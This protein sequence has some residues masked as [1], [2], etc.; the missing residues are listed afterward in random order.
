MKFHGIIPP[1]VTPLTDDH[2]LDVASYERSLNRMIEAGVDGLFVL[3]S[4]SEVVFC[5]DERRRQIVETAMRVADGRVP[6]LVGV[7]DTSTPR[8]LEH[9]RVAE[10]L[11]ADAIVATAP[12]Y[13][14]V[15][16]KEVERHFR[17]IH[18]AT[19]LPIFAYDLPQCVHIKLQGDMLV[20]LGVDG[21]LAG[22]KDSSGD[23]VSFRYLTMANDL[24]GHPLQVFT[25]HEVVVD[26]AYLSG[27]D[28]SVPGLANVNPDL[29]VE[30]WKAYQ[31]GDWDRVRELQ[32]QAARLM[33]ITSVTRGEFGF[34]A[35]VGAFKTA[36]NLM[37][38]FDSAQMPEP[39]LPLEGE[40]RVA[41][42]QVLKQESLL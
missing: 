41:I 34:A 23:D 13:A 33:R 31:A 28:G 20:R 17:L 1:V 21:V 40:N 11:G 3:G 10:E 5:T 9:V 8:V 35:G 29:Y 36:L 7:I 12:F 6:V 26:G 27:A 42:A 24:A 14:I 37:G 4:S 25:G 22:V 18:E 38:V 16:Q 2:E 30:Q 32:T 15:G 39:V 19:D